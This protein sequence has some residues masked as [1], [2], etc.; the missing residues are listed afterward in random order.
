MD[1]RIELNDDSKC[2]NERGIQ[3]LKQQTKL[4]D[5]LEIFKFQVRTEFL[6]EMSKVMHFLSNKLSY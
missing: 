4:C 1:G 2:E 3:Y 5:Y 6:P